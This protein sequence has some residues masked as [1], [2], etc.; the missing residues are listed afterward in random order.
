MGKPL[1]KTIRLKK[2]RRRRRRQKSLKLKEPYRRIKEM[3]AERRRMRKKVLE[4][5]GGINQ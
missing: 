3:R 5:L 2:P 1:P 4:S